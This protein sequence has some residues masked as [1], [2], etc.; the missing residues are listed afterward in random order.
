MMVPQQHRL[1]ES[2]QHALYESSARPRENATQWYVVKD[3]GANRWARP[4]AWIRAGDTSRFERERFIVG[5]DMVA[6]GWFP[7][8]S[9]GAAREITVEDVRGRVTVCGRSAIVNGPTRS[10]PE[11]SARTSPGAT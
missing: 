9:S 5:V 7:R 6:C 2:E 11:T 8:A 1:E 4:A 10:G 3:L